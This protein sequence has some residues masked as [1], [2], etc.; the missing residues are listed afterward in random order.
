MTVANVGN[1]KVFRH[2]LQ[3]FKLGV[4]VKDQAAIDE[5]MRELFRKNAK[6]VE[7]KAIIKTR[8]RRV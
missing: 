7:D 1:G 8:K 2:K 6:P 3:P 5:K 4:M